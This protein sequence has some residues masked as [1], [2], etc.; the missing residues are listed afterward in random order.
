M[1]E[2]YSRI[3]VEF[4]ELMSSWENSIV[5]DREISLPQMHLLEIL[6]SRKELRM[7]ELAGFLGV[8]TGTLTVMIHRLLLKGYVTKKRDESD[9]RSFIIGLSAK[10]ESEYG[11]H[12]QMHMNL[13]EEIID[14]LGAGE[15]D[16][17]FSRLE[18]L[19][20]VF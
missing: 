1:N 16:R 2:R 15:S 3:L 8:T 6:G 11:N 5:A 9:R 13:I 4:F 19:Q 7:K 17:L 14:E 12:H 18:Q 10:G 20:R